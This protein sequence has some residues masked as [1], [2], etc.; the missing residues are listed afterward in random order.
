MSTTTYDAVPA[1]E[2]PQGII[3]TVPA[4]SQGQIVEVAY[5]RGIPAG[6]R[7]NYEAGHGDPYMRE[8]D[9]SDGTVAYYR[10]SR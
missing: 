9:A 3:W 5:S 10:R 6:K 8:A 1:S 7:V 2:V 4:V